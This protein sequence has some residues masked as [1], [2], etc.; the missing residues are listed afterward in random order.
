MMFYDFPQPLQATGLLIGYAMLR[1][2][3]TNYSS[4]QKGHLCTNI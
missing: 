1:S 2:F 4:H 3:V